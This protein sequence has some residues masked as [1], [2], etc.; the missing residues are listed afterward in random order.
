MLL[1]ST[2]AGFMHVFVQSRPVEILDKKEGVRLSASVAVE[3]QPLLSEEQRGRR[4]IKSSLT[5]RGLSS[6]FFMD[7]MRM[8]C[9]MVS[10]GYVEGETWQ[11]APL[12]RASMSS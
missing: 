1:P 3:H 9:S 10:R 5:A 7:T 11:F 4:L 2:R 12:K 6:T 8:V